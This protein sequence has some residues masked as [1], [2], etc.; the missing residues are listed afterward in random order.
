MIK[1]QSLL[2]SSV[3]FLILASILAISLYLEK[4]NQ[5]FQQSEVADAY[6]NGRRINL[7]TSHKGLEKQLAKNLEVLAKRVMMLE[8]REIARAKANYFGACINEKLARAT[9]EREM[10]LCK[11]GFSTELDYLTAQNQYE[12][13]KIHQQLFKQNLRTYGL[14]DEEI[15]LLNEKELN[16]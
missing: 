11:R 15:H 9:L 8:N 16:M 2:Y 12:K 6:E 7:I 1:K 5:K 13:A 3:A 14:T 4:E 10:K